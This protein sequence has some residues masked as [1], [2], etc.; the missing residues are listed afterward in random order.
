M[1]EPRYKSDRV[2]LYCADCLAVLPQ[3]SGVDAVVTDGPYGIDFESNGQWFTGSAPIDGD[4]TTD[5]LLQVIGPTRP[6][7]GVFFYSPYAPLPV[8]FRSVLVWNKGGHVGI[9]GDRETCWKRDFECIGVIDNLDLN[10]K[11]DSAVLNYRALLPPPTGHFAEK[12]ESLMRYLVQKVSQPVAL[13]LDPFMGS[14]TTG[15]AAM[16]TGRR[17]VGIEIDPTYYAI[18]EKRI[19]QAS[20]QQLLFAETVDDGERAEQMTMG[21]S[22]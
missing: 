7:P 19:E 6:I 14:G 16:Q 2:E 8:K 21:V 10:G 3:L 18:A 9:G 1:I 15:V 13:I 11:R 20:R 5:I 4:K 12:P 17:F 22:A